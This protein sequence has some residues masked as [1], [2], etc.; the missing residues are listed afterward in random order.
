MPPITVH[1]VRAAINHANGAK[2]PGPDGIPTL[3]LQK[4][5]PIIEDWLTNL[6]N[7]SLDLG[8]CPEHFRR[9]NTVVIRK[10]GKSD[11]TDPKAYRPIALLSTIGKVLEAVLATRLSYLVEQYDLLPKHH[12]GGRKGRSSDHALHLLLEQ[13]HSRFHE[14]YCLASGLA[15]DLTGA[16]DNTN[17][18]RLLHNLRKRGVPEIVVKWI[19]SFLM[20]R[21]TMMILLEGKMG[22]F[23]IPTGI[24]QGSPLSPILFL[25]FNADL[26]DEIQAALPEVLVIGYVD[27]VFLMAYGDSA[28]EN[29]RTLAR[30]HQVAERWERRHASRFNPK[31][32]QLAHFWRKHPSCYGTNV[33]S[34]HYE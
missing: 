2:A 34:E 25:F 13:T 27:D 26:I 28:P 8:Y 7:A 30:A 21:H 14:G 12:I 17:H 6:F 20:G 19:E 15:L 18:P 5:L 11:Y 10:P 22:S 9:S 16:F 1:E 24:P 23:P 31:K 29:C 3:V 33:D 32:Y 4:M